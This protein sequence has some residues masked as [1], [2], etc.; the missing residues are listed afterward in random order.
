IIRYARNNFETV[1]ELYDTALLDEESSKEITRL[2]EGLSRIGEVPPMDPPPSLRTRLRPYQ[3]QGLGWLCFLDSLRMGG[4]LADEM[5]LGK[6]V[7]VI[8]FMLQQRESGKRGTDLVVLPATLIFIWQQEL[9]TLAPT[10]RVLTL[11][12][13][14]RPKSTAAINGFDVVLTSYATLLNDIRFLKEVAFNYIYLDESQNIKN[15]D[16]QR[17][18]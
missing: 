17:Y 1:S 16:S 10:L 6:T 2:R 14:D 18:K 9:A 12:G 5:G 15:P 11:Y 13:S 7:Q 4:I 8:A 3:R